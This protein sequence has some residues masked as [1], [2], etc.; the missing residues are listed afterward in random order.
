ML[1]ICYIFSANV[2]PDFF[3]AGTAPMFRIM[4]SASRSPQDST[5]RLVSERVILISVTFD[6]KV[7]VPAI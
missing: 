2:T 4:P 1:V 5:L 7:T 6:Y 3:G